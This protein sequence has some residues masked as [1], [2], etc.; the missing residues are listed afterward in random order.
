MTNRFFLF[1]IALACLMTALVGCQEG[2]LVEPSGN[3]SDISLDQSSLFESIDKYIS[4]EEHVL[5][6]T[7]S[8]VDDL[9]A[10]GPDNAG[11][12]EGGVAFGYFANGAPIASFNKA[13][14]NATCSVDADAGTWDKRRFV[15]CVRDVLDDCPA[16]ATIIKEGDEIIAYSKC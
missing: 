10:M 5:W 9:L 2:G 4:S 3:V 13:P 14:E 7:A 11:E 12:L 16:G 15:N 8:G 1:T 6:L